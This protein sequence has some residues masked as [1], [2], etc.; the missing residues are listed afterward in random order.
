MILDFEANMFLKTDFY[1]KHTLISASAS[2]WRLTSIET[3]RMAQCLIFFSFLEVIECPRINFNFKVPKKKL[4]VAESVASR[5]SC[6]SPWCDRSGW[7][8]TRFLNTERDT[9]PYKDR[10]IFGQLVS[11][12]KCKISNFW[13]EKEM[14]LK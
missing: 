5:S 4:K 1:K 14:D 8:L 7:F 2:L 3:F 9:G 12:K 13:Q 11:R 6:H 10:K